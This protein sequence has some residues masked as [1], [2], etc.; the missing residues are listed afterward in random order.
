V[1]HADAGAQL[2]DIPSPLIIHIKPSPH[3]RFHDEAL[4]KSTFY[5]L[6][7]LHIARTR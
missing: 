6:F 7:Y 3:Q 1:V 5:L 2:A 4:Y